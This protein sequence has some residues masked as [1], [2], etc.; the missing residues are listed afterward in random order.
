MRECKRG[1]EGR[2]RAREKVRKKERGCRRES[3]CMGE[4]VRERMKRSE[5]ERMGG[6][7]SGER[8]REGERECV[9]L[10]VCV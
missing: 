1:R 5:R 6:S 2:A 4:W 7:E 3:V 10:C 8:E 9:C